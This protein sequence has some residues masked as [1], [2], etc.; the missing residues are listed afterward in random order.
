MSTSDKPNRGIYVGLCGGGF[1]GVES[2]IGALK[3]MDELGIKADKMAGG[4]A[5]A[6]VAS[7]YASFDLNAER[8]EH[9]I[10]TVDSDTWFKFKPWQL[11]KSIFGTSNYC[12][13][14]T[15]LYQFLQE[16]MTPKATEM[17]TVSVTTLPCYDKE[18]LPATPAHTL[19]S[20]S[21]PKACPPVRWDGKL[22][23]DGGVKDLLPTPD[24]HEIEEYEH[25]YL[26]LCPDTSTGEV[27]TTWKLL[28]ELITLLNAVMQREVDEIRSTFKTFPNVTV[29]DPPGTRLFIDGDKDTF[30]SGGLLQWS[31][32]FELL[33]STYRYTKHKLTTGKDEP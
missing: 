2:A 9:L 16:N 8:L 32:N 26:V 31:D 19:A 20:M 13:D 11:I 30:L 17:V 4:S 22:H 1:A 27:K 15:G 24:G 29:I 7:L 25:I 3:A 14:T 6:L 23:A 18:L 33:E 5:G 10:K 12:Y 28:G 21:I